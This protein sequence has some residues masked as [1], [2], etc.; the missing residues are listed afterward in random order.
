MKYNKI[1][2]IKKTALAASLAGSLYLSGCHT[3]PYTF[4]GTI[5]GARTMYTKA[6]DKGP[7][8]GVAAGI[9]G[10]IGGTPIGFV[11]GL[12]YDICYVVTGELHTDDMLYPLGKQEPVEREW[13]E[14]STSDEEQEENKGIHN[15]RIAKERFEQT[16]QKKQN[17]NLETKVDNEKE[18]QTTTNN[19]EENIERYDF[20]V[21]GKRVL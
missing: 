1:N 15:P 11:K 14:E 17:K 13:F 20:P 8:A 2:L 6:K 9:G 21:K 3:V 16:K 19:S 10:A 4:G 12:F 18:T 7:V 5:G